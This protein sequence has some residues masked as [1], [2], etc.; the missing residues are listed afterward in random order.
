MSIPLWASLS[1]FAREL[2][3]A[4]RM[5]EISRLV[6]REVRRRVDADGVSFVLRDDE[7]CYYIDDDAI[8]TLWRGLKFPTS[9]CIS[10]WSMTN[11]K[12]AFIPDVYQDDRIPHDVYRATFVKSMI[13]IPIGSPDPFAAMGVYWA[14]Y[15]PHV[16]D[17]MLSLLHFI[18]SLAASAITSVHL[19]TFLLQAE[20]KLALADETGSLG[21]FELNTRTCRLVSSTR[22]RQIFGHSV[23]SDMSY[24]ELVETFHGEDRERFVQS[25]VASAASGKHFSLDCKIMRQD[26]SVHSIRVLGRASDVDH[27]P[28]ICIL[29]AVRHVKAHTRAIGG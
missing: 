10:G 28:D 18:A 12:V 27:D 3:A 19:Y 14:N 26:A 24:R 4:R 13:M 15:R 22:M 1:D 8:T 21:S 6:I 29:G 20:K 5:H 16:D 25:I 2:A 9:S 23:K 17:E 7:T 11:D